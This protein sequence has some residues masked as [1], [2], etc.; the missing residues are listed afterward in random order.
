VYLTLILFGI[1][2]F[3]IAICLS[4][5]SARQ[6]TAPILLLRETADRIV[7]GDTL[8]RARITSG[9][10]VED[11]ARSFNLMTDTMVKAQ[12]DISAARDDIQNILR[13]I[14]ESLI[15]LDDAGKIAM[16]NRAT[17]DW[18]GYE[19]QELLGQDMSLVLGPGGERPLSREIRENMNGK[20][21]FANA[22]RTFHTKTG[23]TIPV[24]FSWSV[25]H[26][27]DAVV[28]GI[29]CVAIDITERKRTEA[30]L[31]KSK[32]AAEA[33][34]RAK[35]EFLANMSHEIRTPMNGVL[36]MVDL[37]LET[38]LSAKQRNFANMANRSAQ[39]LLNILNDILDLSKIEAGKL[40][41]EFIDFNVRRVV[42]DVIEL[43][44]VES[45]SRGI[46]IEASLDEEAIPIVRGDP[47][48]LR[49]V[50]VNL[51]GNSVKFTEKGGITI[52]VSQVEGEQEKVT[53]RFQVSDTGIGISAEKR[54]G[55]FDAFTQADA[56]TTRKHG[57]TGLGLAISRQLVSLM[58]GKI[59]VESAEGKGSTFWFTVNLEKGL[60]ERFREREKTASPFEWRIS[61]A[62]RAKGVTGAAGEADW[63]SCR[64]L[65]AEDNR[66]NQPGVAVIISQ[67]G[68]Q[69]EVVY[70][71]R[72]AI[73]AIMRESYDIV[74]MDCQMPEMDGY[75][76]ARIIREWEQ[77]SNHPRTPIIAL[78]ADAMQ[79]DRDKCLAS[80]MD[81]YLPKPFQQEQVYAILKRYIGKPEK[82]MNRGKA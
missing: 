67:W 20:A 3:V 82:S 24:L 22:E 25:M 57:G 29:V 17:L 48:R 74:F 78:A 45:H 6:L 11:L 4:Y 66:V 50:L 7:Q 46:F 81:D 34:S 70:N 73:E 9:D 39:N 33:A 56:S 8:A 75:E 62:D 5:L 16:V 2:C 79:G 15:V 13:S 41:L 43:F 42:N 60:G 37:L 61:S 53:L 12:G 58:G 65:V 64:I 59:G 35:S 54:Q 69:V 44:A 51:V 21:A 40:S 80:G 72:E 71:G 30:I 36:G 26:Q 1:I 76:A 19:E 47:V 68:C 10:E 49:Q 18:L 31:E 14:T 52:G 23:G 38:N 55:I 77:A 28:P 32:E 63:A 27:G